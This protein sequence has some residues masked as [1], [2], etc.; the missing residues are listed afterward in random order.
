MAWHIR[1]PDARRL[2]LGRVHHDLHAVV[3]TGVLV[4]AKDAL[5]VGVR[6]TMKF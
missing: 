6:S 2:V 3:D 4:I 1:P 5:V